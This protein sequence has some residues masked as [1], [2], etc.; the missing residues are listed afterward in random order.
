MPPFPANIPQNSILAEFQE[1]FKVFT[2]LA[3]VGS[4]LRGKWLWA[5]GWGLR[6]PAFTAS[7]LSILSI[8]PGGRGNN[9]TSA[10]AVV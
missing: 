7:I 9:L 2:R 10:I 6:K 1:F 4:A 8:K 5:L 3:D